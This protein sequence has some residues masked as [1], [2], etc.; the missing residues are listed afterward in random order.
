MNLYQIM[1]CEEGEDD[2]D[3][4]KVEAASIE[5]A[6]EYVKV[7]YCGA[8]STEVGLHDVAFAM[9][10]PLVETDGSVHHADWHYSV[11][12]L[13]NIEE[14]M[15]KEASEHIKEK[16]GNVTGSPP[17]VKVIPTDIGGKP[18][19]G[20]KITCPAKAK[21]YSDEEQKQ[22]AYAK[23]Y[24]DSQH[25]AT[26]TLTLLAGDAEP[27]QQALA[28]KILGFKALPTEKKGFILGFPDIQ[29]GGGKVILPKEWQ[30]IALSWGVDFTLNLGKECADFYTLYRLNLDFSDAPGVADAYEGQLAR[31]KVQ[32]SNYLDMAIGG[33]LRH[34]KNKAQRLD[35]ILGK[36]PGAYKM[37][38]EV[39]QY[40]G[41]GRGTAWESWRHT[42]DHYGL[43]ALAIAEVVFKEGGWVGAYGGKPWGTAAQ[44]LKL[45]WEDVLTDAI[46]V[47]TTWGLQHNCGRILNK[48]WYVDDSLGVILQ[49]KQ[50]GDKFAVAQYARKEVRELW[51]ETDPEAKVGYLRN[52][53]PTLL[54][55]LSSKWA[56]KASLEEVVTLHNLL[57]KLAG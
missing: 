20:V 40:A 19:P 12:Y 33:E 9:V 17:E 38:K 31:L 29:E 15:A 41:Q 34:S 36:N 39:M 4:G 42:R 6:V 28:D 10:H 45:W 30:T 53:L 55:K 22:D 49:A 23:M 16:F 43:E 26:D 21:G 24:V 3:F 37:I 50:N 5:A 2:V 27:V 44:V 57:S 54:S 7:H 18:P 14:Q 11:T 56:Q 51:M 32:F 46:L 47:D 25:I 8:D 52:E 13:Y 1:M 48:A 35:A